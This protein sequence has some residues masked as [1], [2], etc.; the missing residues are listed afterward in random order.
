MEIE[1]KLQ[2]TKDYSIFKRLEGNREVL[3][4]RVNKIIASIQNVGYVVSPLIVNEKMEV[5]DGQGRL[6]ALKE[7]DLPVDYI[8][9]PGI[10]IDECISMNINQG[11]W[12]IDDYI[13]SYCERGNP[14]YIMFKELRNRYPA[15]NSDVISTA[16]LR[17]SGSPSRIIKEGT[18]AITKADFDK[19]VERL[20]YAYDI[21]DM[22]DKESLKGLGSIYTLAQILLYCYDYK[23]VDKARL[24]NQIIRYYHLMKPW[25]DV[26][27]CFRQIEDLYNR[28]LCKK[29]YL[30]TIFRQEKQNERSEMAREHALSMP[31]A[32]DGGSFAPRNSIA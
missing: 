1:L 6:E 4:K 28:N 7:L 20:D 9:Q 29:V 16:V 2:R 13:D 10:G 12:S 8:V 23:E 19:A 14:S 11:N 27:S 21:F 24:K 3:K 18:L 32:E 25:I 26:E 31:R 30:F 15:A 17:I 5:I 22:I